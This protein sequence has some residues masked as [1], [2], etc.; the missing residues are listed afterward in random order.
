MSLEKDSA[1]IKRL[2]E[3][4][5][6]FKA[7]SKHNLVKR[8]EDRSKL[9]TSLFR[10]EYSAY[11]VIEAINQ[12]EAAEKFQGID[13]FSQEVRTSQEVKWYD[14]T[15]TSDDPIECDERGREIA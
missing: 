12:D 10:V 8:E 14:I 7:A 9:A 11:L 15:S 2:V 1:E 6:I 4:D 13:L 3:A 5:E